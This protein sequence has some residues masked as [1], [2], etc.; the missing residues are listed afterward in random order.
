MS[1][2]FLRAV[3]TIVNKT[4]VASALRELTFYW[5]IQRINQIDKLVVSK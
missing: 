1:V 5:G 2:T 3:D 4:D